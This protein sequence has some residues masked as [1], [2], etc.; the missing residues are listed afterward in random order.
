MSPLFRS[1]TVLPSDAKHLF[2]CLLAIVYLV[3]F[4]FCSLFLRNSYLLSFVFFVVKVTA[5]FIW[6]GIHFQVGHLS[7]ESENEP[8]AHF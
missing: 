5:K 2:L 8:F 7:R 1:H 4:V 6:K 3:F